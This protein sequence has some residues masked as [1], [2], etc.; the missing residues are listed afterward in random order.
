M[1]REKFQTLYKALKD[2]NP[3][4]V[5]QYDG[6]DTISVPTSVFGTKGI[7]ISILN[8][9]RETDDD[10]SWSTCLDLKDANGKLWERQ[11]SDLEGQREAVVECV[12]ECLKTI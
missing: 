7:W 10:A 3:E 8:D 11:L 4:Y 9:D 12:E 1:T 6:K 5:F 2:K